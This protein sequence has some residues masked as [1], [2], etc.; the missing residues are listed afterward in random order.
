MLESYE[1]VG[2]LYNKTCKNLYQRY[3]LTVTLLFG[4]AKLRSDWSPLLSLVALHKTRRCCSLHVLLL[5]TSYHMPGSL[6]GRTAPIPA[7]L[8]CTCQ[9]LSFY[10]N[11]GTLLNGRCPIEN[12]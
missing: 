9:I 8:G 1:N 12:H 6:Y 4:L 5:G 2:T 3:K 11:V 7:R 10:S